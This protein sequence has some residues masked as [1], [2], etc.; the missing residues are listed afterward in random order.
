MNFNLKATS[1]S[2]IAI[3]L[4]THRTLIYVKRRGII[5]NEPSLMSVDEATDKIV[6]LGNEARAMTGR[7]HSG[8][9]IVSVIIKFFPLKIYSP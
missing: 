6:A 9:K 8:I 3:D 5:L 1:W 2:K 4:G 7:A